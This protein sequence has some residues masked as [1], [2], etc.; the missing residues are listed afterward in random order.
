MPA[1]VV[2]AARTIRGFARR[3]AARLGLVALLA[4]SLGWLSPGPVQA[5]AYRCQVDGRTVYQQQPCE[6]GNRLKVAPAP[7]PNSREF[8]VQ[9]AIG[10]REVIVGMTEQEVMRAVGRPAEVK[11]YP[12][13]RGR[14][15]IWTY[16]Q[17]P[18]GFR[19]EVTLRNGLVVSLR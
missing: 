14:I 15:E 9:R 10:L 12:T 11:G 4:M 19:R 3:S 5:Q 6:G 7:N 16:P 17:A 8:Q 2:A 18:G 1:V 13:N